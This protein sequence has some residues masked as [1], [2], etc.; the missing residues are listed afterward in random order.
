[1]ATKIGTARRARRSLRGTHQVR[2]TGSTKRWGRS[3]SKG[4]SFSALSTVELQLE[5]QRRERAARGLLSRRAKAAKKVEE[6]DAQLTEMG[7]S[8]TGLS[9]GRVKRAQNSLTLT[10]A[11]QKLLDGKEMGIPDLVPALPSVG[12]RSESPNLRTMVNVALLKKDTFKRISRGV[13]T[14]KTAS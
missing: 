14:A 8:P 10:A 4:M 11:L 7:I 12:Y 5:L 13:Y 2:T 3:P 1:M 9:G 6:I